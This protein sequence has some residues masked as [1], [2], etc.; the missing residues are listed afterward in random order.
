MGNSQLGSGGAEVF[1]FG[2]SHERSELRKGGAVLF[3][4]H[5]YYYITH[6]KDLPFDGLGLFVHT[7]CERYGVGHS[8]QAFCPMR[9]MI[10]ARITEHT[11]LVV[12]IRRH[13][14]GTAD[15]WRYI[16]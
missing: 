6:P 2:D 16:P 7:L 9:A 5:A 10:V 12:C 15:H 11:F 8:E 1:V 4:A 14:H 3:I 13:P